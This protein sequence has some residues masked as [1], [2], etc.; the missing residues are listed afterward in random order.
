MDASESLNCPYFASTLVAGQRRRLLLPVL[1]TG[2][3]AAVGVLLAMFVVIRI[4]GGS[5]ET[6]P[7][8]MLRTTV[9]APEICFMDSG[10]DVK[11]LVLNEAEETARDVEVYLRGPGM[12]HLY[13]DGVKPEWALAEVTPR[14]ACAW[15]GD[16]DPGQIGQV[17]FHL[18]PDLAGEYD[19]VA[20][21]TA[22]NIE[23][24]ERVPVSGEIVP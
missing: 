3:L 2:F 6:P 4:Y 16:L 10:V 23:G 11:V 5:T 20:Q 24:L 15:L 8:A 12:R 22:A 19:L 1:R 18:A 14:S 9:S 7:P 21:V 13:C 17:E